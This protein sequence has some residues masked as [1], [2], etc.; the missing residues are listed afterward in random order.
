MN[1]VP[2]RAIETGLE[3][4]LLPAIDAELVRDSPGIGTGFQG[5][6]PYL[7]LYGPKGNPA[8]FLKNMIWL[9]RRL[10]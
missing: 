5:D 3:G 4:V 2:R 8:V 6:L 10:A 9:A 7:G 1:R